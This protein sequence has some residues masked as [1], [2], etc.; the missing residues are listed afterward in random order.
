LKEKEENKIKKNNKKIKETKKQLW[1]KEELCVF[2]NFAS[3]VDNVGL[4]RQSAF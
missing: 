1:R 4:I 2:S 3:A